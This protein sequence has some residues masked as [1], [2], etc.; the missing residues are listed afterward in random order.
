MSSSLDPTLTAEEDFRLIHVIP[1]KKKHQLTFLRD[2]RDA[3]GSEDSYWIVDIVKVEYVD[4]LKV[5]ALVIV[6]S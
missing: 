6:S 3:E 1:R 5:K 4:N 2:G